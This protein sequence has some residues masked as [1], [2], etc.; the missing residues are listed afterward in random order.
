LKAREDVICRAFRGKSAFAFRTSIMTAAQTTAPL[1]YLAYP[2][3][4]ERATIRSSVRS[5]V[6][7]PT[8]M[9]VDESQHTCVIRDLGAHGALVETRRALKPGDVIK[10][11]DV[12]FEVEGVPVE[13][14]VSAEVRSAEPGADGQRGKYGLEFRDLQ[15]TDKL[16]IVGFVSNEILKD[17]DKAT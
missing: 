9:S 3:V 10:D 6:E 7:L 14:K 15:R 17:E 11:I 1:L 2:A 16:A 5:R 4:V 12:A 8:R 13:M